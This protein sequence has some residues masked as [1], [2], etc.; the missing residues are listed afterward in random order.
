M[1]QAR[2]QQNHLRSYQVYQL[3]LDVKS[4]AFDLFK[5][6][7]Y[8]KLMRVYQLTHDCEMMELLYTALL[9]KWTYI[10]I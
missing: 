5:K 1:Q 4:T 2:F 9:Q 8:K 3:F 10:L 7:H 6:S